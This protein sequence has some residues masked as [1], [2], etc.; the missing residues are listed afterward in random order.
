MAHQVDSHRRQGQSEDEHPEKLASAQ[1]VR[2]E[3]G[4]D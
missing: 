1:Y 4:E 2:A 3:G